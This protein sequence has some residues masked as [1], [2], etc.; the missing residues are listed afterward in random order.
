MIALHVLQSNRRPNVYTP[1]CDVSR[2]LA[3]LLGKNTL[4]LEN[5]E[6]LKYSHAFD[7]QITTHNLIKE[8]K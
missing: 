1:M 3:K 8:T 6:T 5:I 7:V 4:N 2:T